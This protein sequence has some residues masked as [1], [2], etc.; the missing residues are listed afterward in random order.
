MVVHFKFL[1]LHFTAFFKKP[2]QPDYFSLTIRQKLID[3]G[4]YYLVIQF[5]ICAILLWYP[6]EIAEKLGFY[7]K[8]EEINSNFSVPMIVFSAVV[9]APVIEEGIFRLFLG[10]HRHKTYF[11]WLYYVSSVLFGW[12]HFFNYQ[13]DESHYFF[14][15]FITMTQTFSG[16]MLGY[17]RIMYGFWYGVLLHALF[18][19][20]AIALSFALGY[21]L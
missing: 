1:L 9:M 13:F 20:A 3:V 2:N 17:I 18:N 19:C 7:N 16:L 21:D 10:F 6:V 15:P 12:I 11:N 14:F 8:L 4:C 5:G